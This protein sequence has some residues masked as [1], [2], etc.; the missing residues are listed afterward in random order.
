MSGHSKW[1]KIKHQKET[2]DAVKGKIFTKLG[3]VIT[4]AVRE[5]GGSSDPQSNFKLRLAIEKA[6]QHNMPK[7]NIDRALERALGVGEGINIEEIIYEG[8]GPSGV[9]LIIVTTTDNKQRT[10]AEVKNILERGGGALTPGAVMPLYDHRG[11]IR[12]QKDPTILFDKVME[13]SIDKGALDIAEMSGEIEIFTRKEEVHKIKMELEQSGLKIL[14][15][16]LIFKPTIKIKLGDAHKEEIIEN[17][18]SRLEEADDIQKVY[19]NHT[20]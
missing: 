1:S 10:V 7:A 15:Y 20:L 11:L 8:M 13:L 6:H 16:E 17:L 14:S 12:V 19:S 2:T 5:G 3:N 4:L 9:G 18:I